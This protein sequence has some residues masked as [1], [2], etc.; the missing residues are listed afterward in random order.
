MREPTIY[1]AIED[2]Q[3]AQQQVRNFAEIQKSALQDVERQT[4]PG[5]FLGHKNIPVTR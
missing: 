4:L 2:I 5:V 3:F 1:Q